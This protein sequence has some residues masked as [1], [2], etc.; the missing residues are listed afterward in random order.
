MNLN[1]AKAE[2]TPGPWTATPKFSQRVS[3]FSSDESLAGFRIL[4]PE[5]PS[6]WQ[7]VIAEMNLN[8]DAQSACANALLIAK[9][10]ELLDA[11]ILA[12]DVLLFSQGNLPRSE[13]V[14]V[15][16]LFR[17]L[18]DEIEGGSDESRQT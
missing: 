7:T 16:K 13:I 6:G 5:K 15:L 11:I 8:P 4:G 2:P 14:E 3:S 17:R 18:I 9:A 1:L 10:P 12:E